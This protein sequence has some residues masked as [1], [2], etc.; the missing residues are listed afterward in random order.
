MN[1]NIEISKDFKQAVTKA[2]ISIIIFLLF[3]ISILSAAIYLVSLAIKAGMAIIVNKPSFITLVVG[4]LIISFAGSILFF[5]IKFIFKPNKY[6]KSHYH[7]ITEEEEPKLFSFV[8]EIVQDVDVDF[9][10]RIYLTHEVNACVFY[11]STFLSMFLP[12]RK[13]LMIGV[14]LI[15]TCTELELKA[16]IAHEFGHFSQR[17]MKMGSYVNNVNHIIFNMLYD[18]DGYDSFMRKASN[19]HGY[20][21]L[22]LLAIEFVISL[23]KWVLRQLYGLVNKSYLALS[24]QMEYHADE[25]A[26]TLVGYKPLEASLYR[27]ELADQAFNYVI[28]IYAN[29]LK[30]L[31][32]SENIFLEQSYVLTDLGK[33]NNSTFLAGLPVVKEGDTMRFNRSKI[34]FNDHWNSHPTTL[35]RIERLKSLYLIETDDNLT[36]AGL[37]FN[38][39]TAIQVMLTKKFFDLAADNKLLVAISF[40]QFKTHYQNYIKENTFNNYYSHYYD[41]NNIKIFDITDASNIDSPILK[42]ELF[43]T[44]HIELS[45]QLAGLYD[46]QKTINELLIDSSGL[47]YLHYNKQKVT[48]K[49]YRKLFNTLIDNA[50]ELEQKLKLHD[51][52]V[53]KYFLQR[54]RELLPNESS[55]LKTYYEEL[56]IEDNK[57]DQRMENYNTV[58][59]Y[60]QQLT[61]GINLDQAKALLKELERALEPIKQELQLLLE[62]EANQKD[63]TLEMSKYFDDLKETKTFLYG[64]RLNEVSF[65]ALLYCLD[66]Y[67]FLTIRHFFYLKKRVLDYQVSIL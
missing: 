10:K 67:K 33:E 65:E 53:F 9:P 63:V 4:L 36:R 15:N 41:Y 30:E 51:I 62:L 57:Y 49:N 18:N 2:I 21:T 46:D 64:E 59:D 60:A 19:V 38:D 24:K 28:N 23:I 22:I 45:L 20:I 3:Y 26:A 47:K 58:I 7:E 35:Q 8:R 54:E 52:Q 5:L 56:F 12:V 1:K 13:N 39:F 43:D 40:S 34:E 50:K 27:M 14:G 32:R 61:N 29:H 17:S 37:L 16:I 44:T 48:Q 11:D 31:S 6:D 66:T 42:R 25:V 55:I